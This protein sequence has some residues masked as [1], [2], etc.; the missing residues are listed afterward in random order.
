MWKWVALRGLHSPG[1]W[2]FMTEWWLNLK[3]SKCTFQLLKTNAMSPGNIRN[4]YLVTWDDN[5]RRTGTLST[6]LQKC[7]SSHGLHFQNWN[8]LFL[9]FLIIQPT[10]CTNFTTFFCHETLHVLDSSSV[11]HQ[12]FIHCAVSNGIGHTGL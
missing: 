12:E 10:R 7:E 11:H 1:I 3:G 4:Q 9:F 8:M 6:L 5:R 2:C